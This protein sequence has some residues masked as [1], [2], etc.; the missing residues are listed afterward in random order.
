MLIGGKPACKGLPYALTIK[1]K[2][3]LTIKFAVQLYNSL[4]YTCHNGQYIS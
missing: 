4:S 2:F 3:A 1:P